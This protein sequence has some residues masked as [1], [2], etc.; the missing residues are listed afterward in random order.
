MPDIIGF[1][2]AVYT[3]DI[4]RSRT[5]KAISSWLSTNPTTQDGHPI[6]AVR[7]QI[8]CKPI[9]GTPNTPADT[10]EVVSFED[11]SV[12]V[13]SITPVFQRRQVIYEVD[14]CEITDDH[15]NGF[16]DVH[17]LLSYDETYIRLINSDLMILSDSKHSPVD[18][19]HFARGSL[20]LSGHSAIRVSA[21][22]WENG[23]WKA[24]ILTAIL[25][26]TVS[27]HERLAQAADIEK[28]NHSLQ[29]IFSKT[30]DNFRN[31]RPYLLKI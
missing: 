4:L 20:M 17:F 27:Q 24:P 22:D 9:E 3:K 31:L 30:S 28:I 7:Q 1:H 12:R 13:T 5:R 14:D 15:M 2:P 21:S 19:Y 10:V 16:R 26:K 8:L 18:F 25:P 23:S 11:V 6:L 29:Q